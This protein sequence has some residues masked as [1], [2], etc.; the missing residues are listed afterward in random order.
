MNALGLDTFNNDFKTK[1]REILIC[2]TKYQKKRV[3][4]FLIPKNCKVSFSIQLSLSFFAAKR[5]RSNPALL[6]AEFQC[7]ESHI[8]HKTATAFQDLFCA[9]IKQTVIMLALRRQ[10]SFQPQPRPSQSSL[11]CLNPD[12]MLVLLA[13]ASA[14]LQLPLA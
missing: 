4:P 6:Y 1:D 11:T 2:R 5:C 12:F 9:P 14:G 10:L 7:H 3:C 13:P 8:L